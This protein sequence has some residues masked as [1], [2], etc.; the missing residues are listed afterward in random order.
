MK[1]KEIIKY[2]DA[3]AP[4]SLK[5]SYDNVGLLIGDAN[6]DLS[7]VLVTLDITEDIVNEAILRGCN[8]IVSHH[9]ILFKGL[10]K[11]GNN[12]EEERVI[13]KV[14][15]H[16]IVIYASH[17]NLDNIKGGVNYKL[18]DKIGLKNVQ[19]LSPK[20]NNLNRL[21]TFCP[22]EYKQVI[23]NSLFDAGAGNI[24]KYQNCSFVSM[25]SGSFTPMTEAN[26]FEGKVGELSVVDEVKV[27]VLVPDYAVN[28]VLNA[29]K[30]S[31][32]YEEVA[33][34][35]HKIE[36]VNQETGIGAIGELEHEMGEVDFLQYLKTVL[37]IDYIKY[38]QLLG[39]KIKKV[40]LC[41][42]SGSFLTQKAISAGAD[43]FISADFKYHDYFLAEKKILIADIGHYETEICT[44]ELFYEVI[45]K[46]FSNIVVL[47]S[48]T[49]TK[50]YNYI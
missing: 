26:P 3:F 27:E 33:Y 37:P 42:G 7:A 44:K 13:I 16:D 49:V 22:N 8:F 4:H 2:L 45:T 30:E 6:Q 38:T 9:P 21:I 11:I 43:V 35:L 5:E 19:I 47:I 15:K 1:I 48:D 50:P 34:Y 25:G 10:Q 23:L 39:T 18:A 29:L 28:N 36:N 40:A 31:H 14:I 12:T 41:G 46:K 20:Y 24:G 17:T 32:P